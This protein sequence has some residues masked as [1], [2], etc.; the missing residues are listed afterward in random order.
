M[1]ITKSCAKFYHHRTS[2]TSQLKLKRS[3]K[4]D[5]NMPTD[6]I[7]TQELYIQIHI[8]YT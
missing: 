1:N 2:A 4:V 8:I 5:E 3:F 7:Y 6:S